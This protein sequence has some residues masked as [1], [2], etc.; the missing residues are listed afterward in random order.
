MPTY[1]YQCQACGHR[2]EVFQSIKARPK[3]KCPVCGRLRLRRL[4]G[5]G[6]GVIFKGSGFYQTDYRSDSYRK[7]AKADEPG[8][9]SKPDPDKAGKPDAA[10]KAETP[11]KKE[12]PA[13]ADQKRD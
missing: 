2:F 6:A 1:D 7:A 13:Q 3:R 12:K 10:A 4:I 5:A 11:A 9:A 8:G